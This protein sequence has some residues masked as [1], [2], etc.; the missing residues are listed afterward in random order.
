[1]TF[2]LSILLGTVVGL[3]VY[4]PY[5]LSLLTLLAIIGVGILFDMIGVAVAAT[6]ERPLHAM[7]ADRVAGSRQAIWLVRRAGRV[8]NICNDVIGDVSGTISGA[9]TVTLAAALA[10]R[11]RLDGSVL[12]MLALAMTA[13]LT[14]GG[15]AFGKVYALRRPHAVIIAVGR[16]LA[17]IGWSG[18]GHKRSRRS[19]Q[20]SGQGRR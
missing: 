14:V 1:M 10:F 16:C 18:R 9:I 17:W 3:I 2:L 13:A 12:S 20:Q 4:L 6:E 15:K 5:V 7:A 11:Y 8:A 19:K